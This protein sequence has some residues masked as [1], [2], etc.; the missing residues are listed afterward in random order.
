[1][2][3]LLRLSPSPVTLPLHVRY[4]SL[5][6]QSRPSI[7]VH[8]VP[9]S[10]ARTHGTNSP[11]MSFSTEPPPRCLGVRNR[12]LYAYPLTLTPPSRSCSHLHLCRRIGLVHARK[13]Q[14]QLLFSP[15]PARACVDR[16]RDRSARGGMVRRC[17]PLKTSSRSYYARERFRRFS[18]RDSRDR[19]RCA[20][21]I[22]RLLRLKLG[23]VAN[24][25]LAAAS[26]GRKT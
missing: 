3:I 21:L 4:P 25:R 11:P 1:M 20:W 19:V 15:S 26:D 18:A 7:S 8:F 2:P 6:C 12:I 22:F 9:W 16:A 10:H 5:G 17:V 24:G 14:C 13:L 23:F